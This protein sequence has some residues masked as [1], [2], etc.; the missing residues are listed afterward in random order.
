MSKDTKW[1]TKIRSLDDPLR[2]NIIQY[3]KN[4]YIIKELRK[5]VQ[6]ASLQLEANDWEIRRLTVINQRLTEERIMLREMN[7]NACLENLQLRRRVR[8][9]RTLLTNTTHEITQVLTFDNDSSS[10][11]SIVTIVDSD[12]DPVEVAP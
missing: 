6:E 12:E 7:H 5:H 4:D 10:E 11:D 9:L 8:R 3:I 1:I 2:E